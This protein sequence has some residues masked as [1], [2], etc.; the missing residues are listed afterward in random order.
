MSKLLVYLAGPITG[1]PDFRE[2]FAQAT[3]EVL[4]LGHTPIS[5]LEVCTQAG[6]TEGVD[7][8]RAFMVADIRAL[9]A[10][11]GLYALVGW[12]NS[13][14]ARLEHMIAA[15]LNM[16]IIYQPEVRQ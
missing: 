2:R 4:L 9:L 7:S 1:I 12:E 5:P 13:K 3:N 8:Y 15:A 16:E 10:C 11:E 6:L 14:G